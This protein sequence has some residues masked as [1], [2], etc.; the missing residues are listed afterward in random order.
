MRKRWNTHPRVIRADVRLSSIACSRLLSS[1]TAQQNTSTLVSNDKPQ[2]IDVPHASKTPRK[3]NTAGS[4]FAQAMFFFFCFLLDS[5][6][7]STTSSRTFRTFHKPCNFMSKVKWQVRKRLN[8]VILPISKKSTPTKKTLN[9]ATNFRMKTKL[10]SIDMPD[11]DP[12][13]G[14]FGQNFMENSLSA[15]FRPGYRLPKSTH[16]PNYPSGPVTRDCG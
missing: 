8:F 6:T 16:R 2:R 15:R 10:R 12:S 1:K 5:R 3:S 9:F 7:P 14:I 13:L 4:K 11:P